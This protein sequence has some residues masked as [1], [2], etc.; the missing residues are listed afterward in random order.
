MGNGDDRKDN[1]DKDGAVWANSYTIPD[2]YYS[3]F[4]PADPQM[5]L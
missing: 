4:L 3:G 1:G 2:P 5:N